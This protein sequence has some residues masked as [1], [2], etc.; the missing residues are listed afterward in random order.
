MTENTVHATYLSQLQYPS[1]QGYLRQMAI[2]DFTLEN[3][4][5]LPQ[6]NISYETWGTL[7]EA[8]DNAILILHALTGDTHVSRGIPTSDMPAPSIRAVE[9]DGW[10]EGIVGPGAVVDTTKYFVIAPNILG[11]CYG[12]VPG[13]RKTL[14]V[15]LPL[16][17]YSRLGTSRSR[18]Y[19]P[20]GD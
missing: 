3:G 7:N 2:G 9:S 11:G 16:R 20:V 1:A 5:V 12:S 13:R 15:T 19:R 18:T 4:T 10:W 17:H 6:V 8:G 14:G